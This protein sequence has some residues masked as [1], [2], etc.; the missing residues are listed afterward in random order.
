MSEEDRLLWNERH[1]SR[2]PRRDVAP[3][4]VEA[5]AWFPPQG[6]VLDVAGGSGRNAVWLAAQ[7]FEV[8]LVDVSDVAADLANQLAV[9]HGVKVRTFVRDFETRLG[10]VP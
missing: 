8:S 4:V 9:E 7:G 3:F 1:R 5:A 10:D 2:E 6:H